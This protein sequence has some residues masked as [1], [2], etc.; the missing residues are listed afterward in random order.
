[1][2]TVL[3]CW[4]L[5][6]M[7]FWH[8]CMSIHPEL[9][10]WGFSS[11]HTLCPPF[12][13]CFNQGFLVVIRAFW[14]NENTDPLRIG[15]ENWR[16]LTDVS[17]IFDELIGLMYICVSP[18]PCFFF[19]TQLS[20]REKQAIHYSQKLKEK[21]QHHPQIK[22]IAR[23]RHL[24]KVIHHQRNELRVMKEARRRKCVSSF[25]FFFF[26][27]P[28]ST[29]GRNDG[30]P[31]LPLFKGEVAIWA[32]AR[33]KV[34]PTQL[35]WWKISQMG[36]GRSDVAA[37]GITYSFTARTAD[38]LSLPSCESQLILWFASLL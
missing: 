25:F 22:R 13:C 10:V 27:S 3:Y 33:E 14:L 6:L 38:R 7:A 36:L 23:H 31:S 32:G 11:E 17:V 20:P 24:P 9:H 30:N 34:W 29:E 28:G 8:V 1:M 15:C 19:F 26:F 16:V 5:K 18:S 35:S 12:K 21:F 37:T 4:Y 2:K